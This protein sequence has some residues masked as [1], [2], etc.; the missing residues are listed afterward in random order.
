MNNDPPYGRARK[1]L[2]QKSMPDSAIRSLQPSTSTNL[3][4]QAPLLPIPTMP[5]TPMI[6]LPGGNRIS[7]ADLMDL[8]ATQ[9]FSSPPHFYHAPTTGPQPIFRNGRD[10]FPIRDLRWHSAVT[11]NPNRY[12]VPPGNFAAEVYMGRWNGPPLH[13]HDS[14]IRNIYPERM[15]GG[16]HYRIDIDP[17]AWNNS[18]LLRG[19]I[20]VFRGFESDNIKY[21][22]TWKR[23]S[24]FDDDTS[25]VQVNAMGQYQEAV[26]TSDADWPAIGFFVPNHLCAISTPPPSRIVY[27]SFGQNPFTNPFSTQEIPFSLPDQ[28][29]PSP[30]ERR[31][32]EVLES[33]GIFRKLT[34]KASHMISSSKD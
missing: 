16:I 20:I 6:Q 28:S 33:N 2:R 29:P 32:G 4:P 31:N 34:R 3:P 24:H 26:E 17:I 11:H 19:D 18:P 9:R 22:V 21:V 5:I 13:I 23:T 8:I 1:L 25:Y 14:S 12:E 7:L 15:F 27:D 30:V 10:R